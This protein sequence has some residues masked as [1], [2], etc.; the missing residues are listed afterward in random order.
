MLFV[1]IFKFKIGLD[2]KNSSNT[3][4]ILKIIQIL[5][6]S[7]NCSFKFVQIRKLFLKYIKRKKKLYPLLDRIWSGAKL[8][9]CERAVVARATSV[10]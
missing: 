8:K 9:T 1:Q 7:K 2:S 5:K 6:K 3:I 10:V 4:F